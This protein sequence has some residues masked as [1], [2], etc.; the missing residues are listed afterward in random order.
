MK[1]QHPDPSQTIRQ[2][3]ILNEVTHILTLPLDL[4]ETLSCMIEKIIGAIKPAE[5]G[6]VMLWDQSS[7]FFRTA[8]AFGYDPVVIKQFGPLEGESI[9]GKVFNTRQSVLLNE[10]A[11]VAEMMQNMRPGNITVL[12]RSLGQNPVPFSTLAVPIIS[13][14]QCFG[15]LL[16]EAINGPHA[17][18]EEDVPFVSNLADLI[19]IAIDR[20]RLA[21]AADHKHQSHELERLRSEM[22]AMLSHELRLP[23]TSIK[24]YTSAL[25]LDKIRWDGEK[26]QEFL[27]KIDVE[28]DHMQDMIRDILDSTL[29]DAGKLKLDLQ[30][31]RLQHVAKEV[32][33]EIQMSTE[34][35]RIL[36]DFPSELPIID[37][38]ARRIK[39]VFRNLLE[40]AIK[41]SPN[42]GLI[43]LRG[44]VR[45]EDIVTSIAD[46]G[47]GI[48]PE[49]LISLFE[50]YRRVDSSDRLHIPGSGIGLPVARSIVEAHG[51]RIWVESQVDQ[52]TT[53]F[54]SIPFSIVDDHDVQ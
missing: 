38:D 52:G 14:G 47:I 39:Q 8:A 36:A 30:P 31:V 33:I 29:I 41:Y 19:A 40:N 11:Q 9:T 27:Q 32:A 2:M 12:E 25:L 23:L 43:V 17:F 15:V 42:G 49:D 53:I 51:G 22:M 37:G 21:E 44:E 13:K 45:Q 10:P 7:G 16:L 48:S 4:H 28:V 46:Q 54:F 6:L 1:I 26:V 35:H 34:E 24:G 18:A 5:V 20:F 50:K 3:T